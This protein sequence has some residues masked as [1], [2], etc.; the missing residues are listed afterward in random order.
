[1]SAPDL[2]DALHAA[3]YGWPHASDAEIYAKQAENGCI[4]DY[5]IARLCAIARCAIAQRDAL[6]AAISAPRA[7]GVQP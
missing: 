1:M 4:D 6:A 7:D 2:T 3:L 5:G